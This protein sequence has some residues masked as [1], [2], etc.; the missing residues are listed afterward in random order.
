MPFLSRKLRIRSPVLFKYTTSEN[1]SFET[2]DK[3]FNVWYYKGAQDIKCLV[4][5]QEER[6]R[7]LSNLVKE[8]TKKKNT[9]KQMSQL[10]G[11]S[12]KQYARLEAGTSDGSV[13][14]WKQ[15]SKFFGVTIDYLLEQVEKTE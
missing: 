15:L 8:R 10:L 6:V 11:I 14:V 5:D 2:I 4:L 7:L 12:E 9:K 3:T 13:K 1:F